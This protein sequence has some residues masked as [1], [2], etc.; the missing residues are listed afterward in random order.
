M[1]TSFKTTAFDLPRKARIGT[2]VFDTY[3]AYPGLNARIEQLTS[4]VDGMSAVAGPRG[5]DL[6]ILPEDALASKRGALRDR[7]LAIER[8]TES[9]GPVARASECYLVVPFFRIDAERECYANSAV[10]LDRTGT[11]VGVYDKMHPVRD[12]AH[13]LEGGVRPGGHP[14]LFD[15]DFGRLGIQI[16]FDVMYS[17]GWK[18]LAEADIVAWPTESPQTIRPSCHAISGRYFVVSA[19]TRLNATVFAPTGTMYAHRRGDGVLV[20][21]VDLSYARL[22]WSAHLREGRTIGEAYGDAVS[23]RYAPS[24]DIGLF[25]SND[26]NRSIGDMLRDLGLSEEVD[27]LVAESS[28][29]IDSGVGDSRW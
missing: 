20:T 3:A 23:Y 27:E 14:P 25:W 22:N 5:L 6:A 19:T 7:V 24:E 9:F 29:R 10:L 28:R 12:S 26:P 4:L 16:C 8:V 13:S 18:A 11:V 15:C 21:E 1:H 2:C 17:D